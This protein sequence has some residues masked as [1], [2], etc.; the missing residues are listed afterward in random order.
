LK[1]PQI[2]TPLHEAQA[3]GGLGGKRVDLL[4]RL[5]VRSPRPKGALSR[6]ASEAPPGAWER[7]RPRRASDD[8]VRQFRQAVFEGRLKPGDPVGSEQRLM[9]EFGASRNTIR[10]A[11]R[12]LEAAGVVEIRTGVKGGV[13]IGLGD[14]NRFADG[15]AVQLKLVGLSMTDALVAQTG[16]DS[17]AAELAAAN[18]TEHDLV[19]M[20]DLLH[21]ATALVGNPRVFT[22]AGDAF[23]EAVAVACHNWAVITSLRAI[24]QLLRESKVQHNTPVVAQRVLQTHGD[25]YSAIQRR[26]PARAGEM[27]RAHVS[28]TRAFTDHDDVLRSHPAECGA[29]KGNETG[30]PTPKN[31]RP[32]VA[33]R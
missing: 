27:M 18:A 10:D 16:L 3:G 15:L 29:E 23:H 14:P 19:E 24:R 9:L 8:I 30:K 22:E 26:D 31:P 28:T 2:T 32:G 21:A 1:P 6:E 12:A 7:I 5:A 13:R 25:I 33:K 4:R 11:L 20:Q 17:L